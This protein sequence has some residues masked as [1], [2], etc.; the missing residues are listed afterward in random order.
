MI[1]GESFIEYAQRIVRNDPPCVYTQAALTEV[2]AKLL[3]LNQQAEDDLEKLEE[4][5]ASLEGK[6]LVV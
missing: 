3:D 5:M 6:L 1:P 4:R 2:I